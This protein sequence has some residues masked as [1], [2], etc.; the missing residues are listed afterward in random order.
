MANSSYTLEYLIGAKTT[1][2]YYANVNRASKSITGMEGT[3]KRA[4]RVIGAA[5]A[6]LGLKR[7]PS[8][9]L[10]RPL[11]RRYEEV[12]GRHAG[13]DGAHNLRQ[14]RI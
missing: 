9:A 6:A 1:G 11:R 12:A 10:S 13:E 14:A 7:V 5:F 2:S 3:A 8:L 4:T